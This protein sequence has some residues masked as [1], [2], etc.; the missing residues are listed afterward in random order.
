MNSAQHQKVTAS[1]LTRHAYLYVRQATTCQA[2]ENAKGIQ[3]QYNLKHRAVALGWPAE[4][5][6]VIDSDLGQSGS[7]L[8]HRPGFEELI[9]QVRLRRV[10]IVI[11]LE[12]SRLAR[13]SGDWHRLLDACATSDTLLLVD[14]DGLYDSG[15]LNDRLVLAC[16]ATRSRAI[17]LFEQEKEAQV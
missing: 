6:I 1:H 13:N 15:D 2:R 5:V 11:A 9:R 16:N 4:H 12:S 17:A 10:G 3:R 7:G 14:Q 8:T